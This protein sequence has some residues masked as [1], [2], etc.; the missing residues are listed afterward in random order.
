MTFGILVKLMVMNVYSI[1]F[2]SFTEYFW[3][4]KDFALVSKCRHF[5]FVFYL[6]Y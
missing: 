5:F 6:L 3:I 4:F 1:L 2:Y